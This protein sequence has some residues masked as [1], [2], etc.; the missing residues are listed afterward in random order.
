LE[1][2]QNNIYYYYDYALISNQVIMK[3][4]DSAIKNQIEVYYAGKFN[5]S[6]MRSPSDY[7]RIDTDGV[8]LRSYGY[9]MWFPT[10]LN[11]R[12]QSYAV[13]VSKATFKYPSDFQAVF[14]GKRIERYLDGNSIVSI[15]TAK[16]IDL[17][18]MQCTVQRFEVITDD[19]LNVFHWK[20]SVSAKKAKEILKF[21][22]WF[23]ITCDKRYKNNVLPEQYYI[24]EMPKFGDISSD[25]MTGISDRLWKTFRENPRSISTIAHEIVHS[26]V[27]L[28]INRD[29]S[30]YA[31]VWEGFPSYFDDLL[32]K[33]YLGD[34]WFQNELKRLEQSYLTK[35]ETGLNRRGRKLPV[36]KSLDQITANE[37][38]LYKDQFILTSR[39]SLFFNYI[40]V[41]MGDS[42]YSE[43]ERELFDL[44]KMSNKT[45]R[46]LVLKH[47]PGIEEDLNIWLSKIDYPE[48]FKLDNL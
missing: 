15:W 29:D 26:Y 3:L 34:K 16:D 28:P 42:I 36:D 35:K 48:H 6:V 47:L 18:D 24:V 7:M 10:F 40:R 17:R 4:S 23:N 41:K 46:E 2:T 21:T 25:N 31:F 9:S 20:D 13:N 32:L 30:L 33:E 14:A 37:I 38:G 5:R 8:F 1:F 11:D 44:R 12:E 39:T 19:W 27:Q 22:H 43:F 45:F